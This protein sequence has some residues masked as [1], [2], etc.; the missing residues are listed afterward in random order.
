MRVK[1]AD[2]KT[3]QNSRLSKRDK[4]VDFENGTNSRF[5]KRNKMSAVTANIHGTWFIWRGSY[6]LYGSD[7]SLPSPS[8]NIEAWP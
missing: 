5:S 8:S 7:A 6:L 3:K 4:T 1:T 2:F